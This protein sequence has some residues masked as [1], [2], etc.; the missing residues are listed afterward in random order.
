MKKVFAITALVAILFSNTELNQFVKLP[1]LIHHYLEHLLAD[2]QSLFDFLGEHYAQSI[3][4]PDDQHHDHENLPF[5]K[6]DCI[7]AHGLTFFSTSDNEIALTP[8]VQSQC[9]PPPFRVEFFSTAHYSN[10]WQPPRFS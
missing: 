4:H 1:V 8:P 5:K 3:N 9:T 10:I 6:H 2:K 7:H